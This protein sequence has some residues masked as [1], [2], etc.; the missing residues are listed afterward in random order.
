MPLKVWH[1]QN[2]LILKPTMKINTIIFC[3]LLL[4]G[5]RASAQY[6]IPNRFDN[7]YFSNNQIDSVINIEYGQNYNWQDPGIQHLKMD[8]YYPKATL[9]PLAKRPL[10]VMIHAGGFYVGN[11]NH[12]KGYCRRLAK[13]GFVA[14]TIDYR[15][16]WDFGLGKHYESYPMSV[17]RSYP[18][19]CLGDSASSIKALY[20]ALQDEKAAIRFL[21]HN[22]DTV[23]N[24]DTNYIFAGGGSAGAVSALGLQYLSQSFFDTHFPYLHLSDSLGLLESS[25]NS[26]TETFSLAGIFSMWGAIPDTALITPA[27]NI[28]TLMIHCTGDSLVPC[29]SDRFF[30]CPNYVPAMGSCMISQRL[31]HLNQCFEFNYYDAPYPQ[32]ACHNVYSLAYHIERISKFAKRVMCN[33]C[34]QVI[35]ENQ[36]EL[37]NDS[38]STSLDPILNNNANLIRVFP[39]PAKNSFHISGNNS[40][41]SIRIYSIVGQIIQSLETNEQTLIISSKNMTPGIYLLKIQT[42]DSGYITKRITIE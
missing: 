19:K 21:V 40:I 7:E 36:V 30:S 3:F 9:D 17:Q 38:L 13:R 34:R 12:Y 22:A 10:I 31:K 2:S 37:S 28:P 8:V 32:N 20:R 24:I 25:T 33:D 5:S 35:I 14:A 18:F 26:Y 41:T 4:A 42:K 23:I 39:N 15:L 11:K 6:C 29:I 16:G 1:K 27:N